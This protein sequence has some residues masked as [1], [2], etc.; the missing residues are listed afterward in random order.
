MLLPWRRLLSVTALGLFLLAA[1][2]FSP[3]QSVSA[4]LASN[5][6]STAGDPPLI[7]LAGY[8]DVIAKYRGKGV[9]V[10][11]WATW[12]EPCRNEYPLVVSLAKEYG[13]QG[14]VVVGVSLDENSDLNLV[15]RFLAQSHP[16]FPN[17]RQ[18]PG[19]DADAFYQGVSPEWKGAMPEMAF[20]ARDGHLARNFFGERQRE[21][22]VEAIR[23]IL[24][25]P[26][27]QNRPGETS[28]TGS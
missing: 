23:L 15:R 10:T 14:L 4:K 28:L 5:D 1:F 11:F 21:A 19:I 25:T 9:L 22:F 16:G 26:T 6:D 18:K 2:G 8:K 20:Y 24:A 7:D 27:A 17:Y 12:C 13:P 3:P